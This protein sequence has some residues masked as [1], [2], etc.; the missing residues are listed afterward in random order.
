MRDSFIR[1][2][3]SYIQKETRKNPVIDY[4]RGV[5]FAGVVWVGEEELTD[6][7]H[8]PDRSFRRLDGQW[9]LAGWSIQEQSQYA[10]SYEGALL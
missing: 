7:S 3:S 4:E 5:E 2:T 6:T 10:S 9:S 8:V 1:W